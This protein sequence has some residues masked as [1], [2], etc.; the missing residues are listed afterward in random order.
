[1]IRINH[2]HKIF[3]D[4]KEVGYIQLVQRDI[5][6]IEYDLNPEYHNQGIM[7]RELTAYLSKIKDKHPKLLAFVELENK[8]SARVL[9]KCGFILMTKVKGYLVFVNDLLA[10]DNQKIVM[11]ELVA[12]GHV[13][14][15]KSA[16]IHQHIINKNIIAK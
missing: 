1:M 6:Q 10:S 4:N 14:K 5:P 11:K 13:K 3:V 12:S 7:T 15:L 2:F 16:A 9:E 8:A